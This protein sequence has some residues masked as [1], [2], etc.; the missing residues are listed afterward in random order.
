MDKTHIHAQILCCVIQGCSGKLN[1][2]LREHTTKSSKVS[3]LRKKHMC[4]RAIFSE[5]FKTNRIL[6]NNL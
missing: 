1:F 5:N 3:I 4:E 2:Y 6:K